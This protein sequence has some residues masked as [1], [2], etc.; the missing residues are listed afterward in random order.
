[1]PTLTKSSCRICFVACEDSSISALFI[2][3]MYKEVTGY[4]IFESDVPQ[5]VCKECHEQLMIAKEFRLIAE[6]SE[7]FLEKQRQEIIRSESQL[8]LTVK[9]VSTDT[10]PSLINLSDEDIEELGVRIFRENPKPCISQNDDP[11]VPQA[12][13]SF[14]EYESFEKE[15]KKKLRQIRRLNK[16]THEGVPFHSTT[17]TFVRQPNQQVF[18]NWNYLELQQRIKSFGKNIPSH[19][20]FVSHFD[21]NQTSKLLLAKNEDTSTYNESVVVTNKFSC[22]F[23][24]FKVNETSDVHQIMMDHCLEKHHQISFRCFRFACKDTFSC[25]DFLRHHNTLMHQKSIV[26]V[27]PLQCNY[28]QFSC[29][30]ESNMVKHVNKMHNEPEM[31]VKCECC[32]AKVYCDDLKLQHIVF[33]CP[34][35]NKLDLSIPF[36]RIIMTNALEMKETK[37]KRKVAVL[38]N[39]E[40]TESHQK[41]AILESNSKCTKRNIQNYLSNEDQDFMQ[42]NADPKLNDLLGI[43][44]S[45]DFCFFST[46][47]FEN[48]EEH[49]KVC[50]KVEPVVF[51]KQKGRKF[52]PV[53]Y[54]QRY[55]VCEFCAKEVRA[56]RMALHLAAHRDTRFFCDLC[57]KSYRKKRDL[58]DHIEIIHLGIQIHTCSECNESFKFRSGLTLHIKRKHT[59][60]DHVCDECGKRFFNKSILEYHRHSH[61]DVRD[62]RCTDCGKMC[63]SE[64]HLKLHQKDMHSNKQYPCPTCGKIFTTSK[65]LSAHKDSHRPNT[66]FCPVCTNTY[67][68]SHALRRHVAEKHPEY[69]MPPVGTQ[70][71]NVN[72][73]ELM[74]VAGK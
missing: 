28:C 10:T 62:V 30:F 50:R 29:C 13:L 59:L 22:T 60:L 61:S 21:E 48:L 32:D 7:K 65:N 17:P 15:K 67:S 40:L 54:L 72:I 33:L 31:L 46:S 20:L 12:D 56:N 6:C 66:Y 5:K 27:R 41:R 64:R 70:L 2:K 4:E 25:L 73:N 24:S 3:E 34:Q 55:D 36:K 14:E 23:C 57:D 47:R 26:L 1:M 69:Q 53:P 37:V 9:P 43:S 68:A 74:G 58:K 11:S 35:S 38:Y 71:K 63:K 44:H 19:Y 45:C 39:N 51:T 49:M 16:Q 42:K 8:E 18:V 52:R